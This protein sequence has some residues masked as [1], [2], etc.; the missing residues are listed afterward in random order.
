MKEFNG[1]P[2]HKLDS[3]NDRMWFSYIKEMVKNTRFGSIDLTLTIK[4][5]QVTNIKTR[6]ETSFSVHNGK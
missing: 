2:V 4:G 5:G 6:T 1:Q 3:M